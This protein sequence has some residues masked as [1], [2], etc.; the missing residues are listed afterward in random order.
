MSAIER[1][2]PL[3]AD[4][5]LLRR[6]QQENQEQVIDK[7]L[8]DLR[9]PVHSMRIT[10]E[11]FSRLAREADPGALL[12]RAARY[13]GPAEAGVASLSK[14]TD[15][16]AIY[17]SAP[18]IRASQPIA[19]NEWLAE[20][21]LLLRESTR[22]LH[23]E[24]QSKLDDQERLRADRPRLSHALL[25]W[26]LSHA[27]PP[28]TLSAEI[29]EA[30]RVHLRATYASRDAQAATTFTRTELRTLIEGAGGELLDASSGKLALGFPLA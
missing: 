12:A 25:G 19:V 3:I 24:V 27:G 4:A 10:V 5:A 26:G 1:E 17:L 16:L 21:A 11:L 30:G 20:I 7:L 22:S 13:V 15:R 9:N 8:H 28:V 2:Q 23:A 29:E 14:Q 18:A 6:V